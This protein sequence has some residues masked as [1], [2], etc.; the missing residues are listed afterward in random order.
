MYT[1]NDE[2]VADGENAEAGR[3]KGDSYTATFPV[4]L[5]ATPDGLIAIPVPVAVSAPL[6]LILPFVLIPL[7]LLFLLL[8]P[9][10]GVCS[11]KGAV[12]GLADVDVDAVIDAGEK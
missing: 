11:R 12:P 6:L 3:L 2:E 4:S 5:C 1:C 7:L 9:F 10:V 8:L